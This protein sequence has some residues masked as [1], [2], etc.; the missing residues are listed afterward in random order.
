MFFGFGRRKTRK[1][2]NKK[3]SKKGRK[4][5][6]RL[7]KMCKRYGVKS[8]KKVGK[9]R[10]YK[11]KTV[12]K[13]QL[14]RKIK[15]RKNAF[16]AKRARKVRKQLLMKQKIKKGLKAKKKS[17]KLY[18]KRFNKKYGKK[19]V[20]FRFGD[21]STNSAS[22]N[23]PPRYGYN[24][25]VQQVQGNLSQSSQVVTPSSNMN[26]PPGFG[27]DPSEL[28]IYGVYRP[29]FTEK[30]PTQIGPNSIGFEGQA[31]GTLFPVG[32]PF[33]RYTSFG[34]RRRRKF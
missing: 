27:V 4:P 21:A 30:I 10:V 24:Q 6:A 17:G 16:G 33:A 18:K 20:N 31:D 8:T 26:R 28:P 14:K 15:H 19:R 29:F 12:L 7:I 5:P 1:R 11:S 23:Q 3:G 13:R 9:R 25:G 22:F 34:K 2:T 32:G